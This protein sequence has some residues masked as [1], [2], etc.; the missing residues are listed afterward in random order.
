LFKGEIMTNTQTLA[1]GQSQ[2]PTV[3]VGDHSFANISL[4]DFLIIPPAPIQRN[5]ERRVSKMKPIFDEAYAA[6]QSASLTEVVLGIIEN[7]FD[8][9]DSDTGAVIASYK[10]GEV[11]ILDGN[12]R[13]FYWKLNPER[14]KELASLTAKIHFLNNM[15]D[16]KFAYYPYNSKDSVE[17]ASEI[18]QGLARRYNWQPRQTMFANGGYKTALDWASFDDGDIHKRF[19]DH[20]EELKLLDSIPKNGP[21]ISQP[22]MKCLKSQ[23][24]IAALLIALKNNKNNLNLYEFIEHLSNITED[25]CKKALA[26]DVGNPVEVIAIEWK[27]W[28]S[29]RGNNTTTTWLNGLAGTTKFASREP[30]LDFLLYWISEYIKNPRCTNK[31]NKGVRPTYWENFLADNFI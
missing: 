22:A 30:Q 9:I 4:A 23:P 29:M 16:M 1:I 13:R 2:Y 11:F 19:N 21:T 15:E 24:I 26:A 12:T 18:L 14:A 6:K 7:D 8:D 3:R 31:L 28:S 5:S 27:G 17:K 20:F 10:A 25:D